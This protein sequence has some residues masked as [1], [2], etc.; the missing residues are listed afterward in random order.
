MKKFLKNFYGIQLLIASAV[1]FYF[2]LYK[3][4]FG[5]LF[6]SC[7]SVV[8]MTYKLLQPKIGGLRTGCLI[9]F[10]LAG[11]ITFFC[12]NYLSQ[13]LSPVEQTPTEAG[14]NIPLIVYSFEQKFDKATSGCFN[15]YDTAFA[16]SVQYHDEQCELINKAMTACAQA[17]QKIDEISVEE[18]K[19]QEVKTLLDGLKN[20]AKSASS[21]W[22]KFFSAYNNQCQNPQA[23]TNPTEIKLQ[24]A[25][26]VKSMYV[27]DLKFKKARS[28]N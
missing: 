17:P 20:D 7:F 15:G 1:C 2:A 9:S 21:N 16:K 4:A 8:P 13:L 22:E 14:E 6:L 28:F 27:I 11:G 5:L 23:A 3:V 26:A 24:L 12:I 18:I 19:N 25:N 10:V